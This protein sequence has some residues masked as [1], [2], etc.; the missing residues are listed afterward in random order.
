METINQQNKE[1]DVLYIE[2]LETIDE[3]LVAIS[4]GTAQR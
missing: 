1:S 4:C 2:A 3:I